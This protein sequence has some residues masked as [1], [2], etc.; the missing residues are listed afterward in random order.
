MSWFFLIIASMFEIAWVYALKRVT[1]ISDFSAIFITI[2][3]LLLSIF[4]LSLAIRT[5]PISVA[6]AL[7]TGIGIIGALTIGVILYNEPFDIFRIIC[8]ACIL[9]GIVGIHIAELRN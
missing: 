5:I 7:W 1:D 4:F 2:S 9:V 6:Y 8:V 3:L